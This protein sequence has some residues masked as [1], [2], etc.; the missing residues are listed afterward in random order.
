VSEQLIA[1]QGASSR[2]SNATRNGVILPF[3]TC[4]QLAT[5]TGEAT[6]VCRSN[7]VSTSGPSTKTF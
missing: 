3:S 4:S 5:D 1:V 7:H 6:V 2:A